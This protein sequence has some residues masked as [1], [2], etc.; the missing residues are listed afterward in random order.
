MQNVF[1]GLK[2]V[3]AFIL[4]DDVSVHD[5]GGGIEGIHGGVDTQFSD[6]SVKV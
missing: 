6:G 1:A 3:F 2:N 4:T 5:T